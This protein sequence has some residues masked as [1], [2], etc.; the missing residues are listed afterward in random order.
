MSAV[1]S[2]EVAPPRRNELLFNINILFR[3]SFCSPPNVLSHILFPFLSMRITQKSKNVEPGL[4]LFCVLSPLLSELE[5]PPSKKP[6]S[7]NAIAHVM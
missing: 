4:L 6:E 1:L 5:N 7:G 2:E 3:L